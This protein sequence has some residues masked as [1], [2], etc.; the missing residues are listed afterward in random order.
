MTSVQPSK[1]WVGYKLDGPGFEFRQK[2]DFFFLHPNIQT[3]PGAYPTSPSV[4][5]EVISRG[6]GVKLP[7][8]EVGHLP[9]PSAELRMSGPIPSRP[10]MPSCRGQGQLDRV[11]YFV[12]ITVS[13]TEIELSKIWHCV[14]GLT[15]Q[16]TSPSTWGWR[17]LD[18]VWN[19]TAHAQKPDF[20]FRRNGRVYLTHCGR[21]HLNCLNAR[22]RGF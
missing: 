14:T 18:C 20:V 1:R 15:D 8:L 2:K 7:G 21:G 9:P 5:T 13:E 4:G 10:H 3:G 22:S 12:T 17:Q 19:V 6:R 11:F 16:V